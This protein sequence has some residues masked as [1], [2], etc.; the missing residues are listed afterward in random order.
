MAKRNTYDAYKNEV[1]L[2][3]PSN[4]EKST[5]SLILIV[6]QEQNM[7]KIIHILLLSS[8]LLSFSIQEP[9]T[10]ATYK[11]SVKNAPANGTIYLR[12]N[13]IFLTQFFGGCDGSVETQ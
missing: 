2:S 8:L 1:G 4:R 11:K 13:I 9:K 7:R 5:N 6:W 10:I 12:A 3:F